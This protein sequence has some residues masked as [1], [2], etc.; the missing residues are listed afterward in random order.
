MPSAPFGEPAE[1]NME[2]N[3]ETD[4]DYE[5]RQLQEEEQRRDQ[6]EHRQRQR[7]SRLR[8]NWETLTDEQGVMTMRNRVTGEVYNAE[9]TQLALTPEFQ[10]LM[11]IK[12]DTIGGKRKSQKSRRKS[13][14]KLK[15]KTI[16]KRR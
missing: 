8:S 3:T 7:D 2:E 15:R 1:E 6:E 16:R 4:E 5:A 9:Q 13:K 12:D 14:R 10:E 11:F